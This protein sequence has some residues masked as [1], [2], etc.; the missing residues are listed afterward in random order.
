MIPHEEHHPRGAPDPH[1]GDNWE[2]FPLLLGGVA[3]VLVGLLVLTG[4]S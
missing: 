3:I 1:S 2:M 4:N